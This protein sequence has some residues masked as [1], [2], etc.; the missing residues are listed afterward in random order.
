LS[1]SLLKKNV[2]GK[3]VWERV[4]MEAKDL[5]QEILDQAPQYRLNIEG[6]TELPS[7]GFESLKALPPKCTLEQKC[8]F[9]LRLDGAPLGGG[10]S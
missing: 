9:I 4:G 5:V 1:G 3:L 6:V 2:G 7:S 8:F 10:R